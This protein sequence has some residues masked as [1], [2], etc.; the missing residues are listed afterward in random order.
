MFK[1]LRNK[2]AILALI[3]LGLAFGNAWSS[4]CTAENVAADIRK[5]LNIDDKQRKLTAEDIKNVVARLLQDEDVQ[6]YIS[7][8]NCVE[9]HVV[10]YE[11]KYGIF[12][13]CKQCDPYQFQSAQYITA[14]HA[15]AISYCGNDSKPIAEQL[16]GL[17]GCNTADIIEKIVNDSKPFLENESVT[18]VSF[19]YALRVLFQA[20]RLSGD[21]VS[22]KMPFSYQGKYFNAELIR[23]ALITLDENLQW[24]K[25]RSKVDTRKVGDV[26]ADSAKVKEVQ[27]AMTAYELKQNAQVFSQLK[28]NTSNAI[29]KFLDVAVTQR[30]TPIPADDGIV[31]TV[32]GLLPDKSKRKTAKKPGK[33]QKTPL[34]LVIK[35]SPQGLYISHFFQ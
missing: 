17:A 16:A 21:S 6:A 7:I 3:A 31:L 4:Q 33:P 18:L 30:V 23:A 2:V 13:Y 26:F 14:L 34:K 1:N 25:F 29:R 27:A 8:H 28:S 19:F 35:T 9:G 15:F 32:E 10:Q 22:V 24:S 12:N 5:A 11:E 20:N